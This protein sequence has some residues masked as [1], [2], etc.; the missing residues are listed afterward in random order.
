MIAIK[1]II[2]ITGGRA[3]IKIAYP[4]CGDPEF[5]FCKEGKKF[6]LKK[7]PGDFKAQFPELSSR[8]L[9]DAFGALDLSDFDIPETVGAFVYEGCSWSIYLCN[10]NREAIKALTKRLIEWFRNGIRRARQLQT[11]KGLEGWLWKEAIIAEENGFRIV[12]AGETK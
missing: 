4:C 6:Y 8:E 2:T 5:N 1:R 11:Q 12:K 9:I 7:I 3:I 10:P